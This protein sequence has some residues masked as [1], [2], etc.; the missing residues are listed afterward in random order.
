MTERESQGE[1]MVHRYIRCNAGNL[2]KRS[3]V[4]GEVL[5]R[6]NTYARVKTGA[7]GSAK[8]APLSVPRPAAATLWRGPI[9]CRIELETGRDVDLRSRV[10]ALP[11]YR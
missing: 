6:G 1:M 2:L 7:I 10:F 4:V 9:I 8:W 3:R 11:D 5:G